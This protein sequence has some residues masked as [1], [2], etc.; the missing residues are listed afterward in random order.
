M[1]PTK[2]D[3]SI[4]QGLLDAKLQQAPQQEQEQSFIESL[5]TRRSPKL[6]MIGEPGPNRQQI[7]E[8]LTAASHVPDHGRLVPWRFVVVE[9][10]HRSELSQ[11]IRRRF[12]ALH[13]DASAERAAKM[14]SRLTQAPVVICLIF[15][16][17]NQPKIPEWEQMLTV[18]AVGMNVLHAARAMGF[19]GLWL[20][21]WYAYDEVVTKD[22]GLRTDER[23]AGF[24]HIGTA[25]HTQ[26]Q[27]ERPSIDEI[28]SMY[29][30]PR[31]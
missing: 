15:C 30:P 25:L 17:K 11:T 10:H 31:Q 22:L 21:E 9:G 28:V 4:S 23:I 2:N 14:R 3:V 16:P 18:G 20:T 19:A 27:R 26:P 24:F 29:H 1:D 6:S 12:D 13:P 8:L 5:M 7:D